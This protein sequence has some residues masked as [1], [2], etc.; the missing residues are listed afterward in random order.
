MS[1][2]VIDFDMA[3]FLYMAVIFNIF[4]LTVYSIS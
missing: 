4:M 1:N 2:H 3:V